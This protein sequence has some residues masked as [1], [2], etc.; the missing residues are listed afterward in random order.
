MV[1]ALVDADP[2][3][4]VLEYL[5]A[6]TDVTAILGGAG[7][8][9]GVDRP[10]Y[11]RL[12]VTNPPGGDDRSLTWL[13]SPLIQ[14]EALGDP[15]GKPGNEVLRRVLYTATTALRRLP[16]QPYTPGTVVVTNVAPVGAGG[17]SPLPGNRPRY[18]GQ[19][20]LWLHPPRPA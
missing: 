1:D 6:D 4:L 12:R 11:P 9:G 14:I 16:E 5:A 3:A 18:I 2:V 8:V 20:R 19:V 15:D 17:S 13:V 10:P 7:R